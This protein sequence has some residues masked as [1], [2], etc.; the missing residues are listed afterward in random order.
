M[1]DLQPPEEQDRS[2][3][4]RWPH[5]PGHRP[6]LLLGRKARA[7]LPGLVKQ[8]GSHP[9]AWRSAQPPQEAG[10]GPHPR[11]GP[12]LSVASG[13]WTSGSANATES[14]RSQGS[15]RSSKILRDISS[16]LVS[17][18]RS[19]VLVP[20]LPLGC[21]APIRRSGWHHSSSY[22][23]RQPS[24]LRE[25]NTGSR[26]DLHTFVISILFLLSWNSWSS[27]SS[28]GLQREGGQG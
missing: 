14:F 9:R 6:P 10:S 5:T 12:I 3:I 11:P 18:G 15:L 21:R 24:S 8:A 16:W 2:Q 27:W 23:L 20:T 17:H 4:H 22:S 13:S 1:G 26:I 19:S 7:Q 25:A 28:L